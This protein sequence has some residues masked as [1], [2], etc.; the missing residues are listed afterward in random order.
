MLF[1]L[2][3][4]LP[5]LGQAKLQLGGQT[6]AFAPAHTL[7]G[8]HLS[9]NLRRFEQ[10][11]VDK[12]V[13][14]LLAGT[15]GI[16]FDGVATPAN[17]REVAGLSY[18]ANRPDGQRLQVVLADGKG[19]VTTVT[20]LIPDWQLVPIARFAAKDEG[21]C[22]TLFGHLQNESDEKA[23]RERRERI[24]NYHADFED[25]LLG[26]RLFQADA[27]LLRLY[28]DGQLVLTRD[29]CDLPK[30]DGEYILGD[31][32]MKPDVQANTERYDKFWSAVKDRLMPG[33]EWVHHS[34]VICDFG[35]TVTF[36]LNG[37][38]L[39]LTGDPIW[40]FWGL[41]ADRTPI[42]L[43]Q[44]NGPVSDT[45]KQLEGINPTVYRALVN[46]MRYAA[47][48]RHVKASS[49]EQFAS[50]IRSVAGVGW[51][52]DVSTP[53]VLIPPPVLAPRPGG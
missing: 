41:D 10:G 8:P 7:R 24:I 46:T 32:E 27:L 28:R 47:F 40:Y 18:D 6:L 30:L 53:T 1:A 48:L 38:A 39:S 36:D 14:D 44:L 2:A 50:F 19:T 13:L 43:P 49:P 35:Q 20:A 33:G 16:A 51:E 12:E 17:G 23:R 26:L 29:C 4:L 3:A 21:S 22:V 45:V 25:T 37:Q 31:G 34:Y 42:P 52:P 15:G 11:I 5:T 9:P